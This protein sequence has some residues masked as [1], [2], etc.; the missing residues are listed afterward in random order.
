MKFYFL[1]VLNVSNKSKKLNVNSTLNHQYN[2]E[3]K[4]NP[5]D[6]VVDIFN[7][8]LGLDISKNDIHKS[9]RIK[10]KE[11]DV[12]NPWLTKTDNK[13]PRPI[14]V[15]FYQRHARNFVFYNKKKKLKSTAIV[16]R[17][18]LTAKRYKIWR[19]FVEAVGIKN[20]W[21]ADGTVYVMFDDKKIAVKN[22]NDIPVPDT[23]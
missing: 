7:N 19:S 1:K 21:T 2:Y 8:K 5:T 16:I 17:E 13:K 18:D 6:K 3:K 9:F 12:A 15:E 22:A 20:V 10:L 14:L 11:I 4:E 23:G